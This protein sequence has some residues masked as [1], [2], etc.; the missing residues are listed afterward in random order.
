MQSFIFFIKG[1]VIMA[2]VSSAL[3]LIDSTG[4]ALQSVI[5]S[6]DLATLAMKK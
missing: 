3:Q 1:G 6:T 4:S 2:T 5:T